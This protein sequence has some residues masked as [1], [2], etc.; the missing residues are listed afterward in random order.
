MNKINEKYLIINELINGEFGKVFKA[1]HK[2]S[3]KLVVIKIEKKTEISLL[4]YE[5]KIYNVL[6]SYS[7][8]SN[9]RNFYST[10]S[11]NI[12]IIDYF[13]DNLKIIKNKL[14]IS[15]ISLREKINFINSISINIIDAIEKLHKYEFIY[16]DI[17]PENFCY[18]NTIKLIDLG[19]CKKFINNGNHIQNIKISSIIGTPNYISKS[20]LEL[21]TPSRRDDIESIIYLYLFL[22]FSE[23]YWNLYIGLENKYKKDINIITKILNDLQNNNILN[24]NL[25]NNYKN[26]NFNYI[27]QYLELSRNIKFSEKPDYNL[28]KILIK[29]I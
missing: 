11:E 12:L 16:R 4:L 20:V 28:F 8:I 6:K 29:S 26:I 23:T 15:N 9:L 14:H 3:K 5:T 24:H 25:E 18:N 22:I 10:Q 7:Y 1:Q 17:K 13:G 27:I 19:F 2:I 21:N